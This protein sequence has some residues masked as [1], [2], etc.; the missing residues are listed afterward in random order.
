MRAAVAT[1]LYDWLMF[2]H[3]LAGMVWLGGLATL[4]AFVSLVLR[5]DDPNELRRFT[6]SLGVIGPAVLGPATI[7]VVG[8]GVWLVLDSDVWGFG[9]TWIVVALALFAVAFLVGAVFQSRSAIA[10][11]RAAEAGDH[12]MATRELRHWAWG[13]RLILVLVVAVTWDMVFKP[14]L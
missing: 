2:L 6:A 13:M 5:H 11:Q 10:A 4:V 8:L 9:Q 7:A 12:L 1:S 3:I 14:G